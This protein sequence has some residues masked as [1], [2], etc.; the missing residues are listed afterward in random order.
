MRRSVTLRRRLAGGDEDIAMKILIRATNWVGDAILAIPALNAVR[1]RWPGAEIVALARPWVAGL[2]EGQP[3]LN[4]VIQLASGGGLMDLRETEE[5]TKSL[6]AEQ[7]DASVL[8]PNSFSSAWMAWRADI[9]QRIGYARDGRGLLL[10]RAIAP[11]RAGEIPQH[12]AYYYLNLLRAAGW[13]SSL[14]KV[15]EIRLAISDEAR[16]AAEERMQSEGAA[17]GVPRIAIAAGAAYGSAKCWPPERFAAMAKR[18]IDDFRA[19][20][21]LFG[22]S[23][24]QDI[25]FRIAAGMQPPPINLAGRTNISELPALLAA[26]QLFV[27]NDSGAMHVAAA[28]GVP[29]VGI[30]GPTDPH[31]TAP[32]TVRRAI[33]REPVFCSPCFL[34]KCPI[35]HRCMT[36]VDV[37]A[38]NAAGRRLLERV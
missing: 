3:F 17:P 30:F 25:C 15:E 31:G 10:T 27:G 2:Y 5:A 1:D 16:I 33:V 21:I 37:D 13:L 7:F 19:A 32:M 6:R 29:V 23:S 38:V 11:P 24:E 26:C 35:D 8:L 36:R 9:P 12:E 18:F 4:R 14:P 34:R 22:T 20:V 28:A